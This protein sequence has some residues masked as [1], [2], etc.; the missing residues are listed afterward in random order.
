MPDSRYKIY[1]CRFD[2]QVSS[3]LA[4]RCILMVSGH[5][6]LQLWQIN[7]TYFYQR[8]G[9]FVV[10]L[11]RGL[12][13][14]VSSIKRELLRWF[15]GGPWF[16]NKTLTQTRL[17]WNNHFTVQCLLSAIHWS[18][19][20]NNSHRFRC[21]FPVLMYWKAKVSKLYGFMSVFLKSLWR[22]TAT[23]NGLAKQMVLQSHWPSAWPRHL[24][25]HQA[26]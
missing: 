23:M 12:I 25:I 14:E 9:N 26:S 3:Y 22:W 5:N 10:H 24:H 20:D 1:C 6:C 13:N 8:I 7:N 16:L 21:H 2:I 11:L 4:I 15:A 19:P 17:H 18:T